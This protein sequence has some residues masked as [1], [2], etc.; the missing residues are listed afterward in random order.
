MKVTFY[1]NF[2][3]HHQLSFCEKMY[4]MLG[5][6]FKFIATECIDNERLELGYKDMSKLYPFSIN[7]YDDSKLYE[8]AVKLG[9][10]SDVVII[11]SA[12]EKFIK[13]RVKNNKLT[14]RYSERV[15]KNGRFKV[16][17][18]RV[19]G[20]L[21]KNHIRYKRKN[22]Y[23]LCASAY[24]ASDFTIVGAYKE[25]TFKWGYFPEVKSY[26]EEELLKKKDNNITKILWVGRL[27]DWKH[28]EKAIYVA[29]M[30]KE[31]G[32]KFSMDIIGIG[33]MYDKLN[34]LIKIYKL[35]NNVRMLGSMPPEQVRTYMENSNIFLFTS[36]YN[37]GWGAV[38][39]EAMNSGCAV[40]AS[41]AIGSVP[42]LIK[43]KENGLVYKDSNLNELYENV[44]ELIKNRQL[45]NKLGLN[46]YYTLYNEWNAD[47]AANNFIRLCYSLLNGTVNE[48]YSGP[49]SKEV[50]T[51]QNKM[52]D[53]LIK[54]SKY[55]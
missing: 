12:P 27:I 13:E 50:S 46:A 26:S 54:N 6:D 10:D 23:M 45:C 42:F 30:L 11:G 39:N 33:A 55:S 2:L 17:N 3:N 36:D 7:T 9:N 32:M 51:S 16:L 4:E 38:L 37:E 25:K 43:H 15:F 47:I 53:K 14:F 29:K 49:G 44:V 18:P 21:Y 5:E 35:E 34:Q 40:V 41:H 52:Y 1:S 24:T 20:W 19:F 8:L 22:V 31:R 48:I 28:P